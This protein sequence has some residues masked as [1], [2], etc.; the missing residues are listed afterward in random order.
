VQY[1]LLCTIW[2]LLDRTPIESF[3]KLPERSKAIQKV[4]RHEETEYATSGRSTWQQRA[5]QAS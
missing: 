4:S 2:Q 3:G 5:K 1:G